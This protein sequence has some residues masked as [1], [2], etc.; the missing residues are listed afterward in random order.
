MTTSEVDQAQET[1]A[2]DTP[3]PPA[4]GRNTYEQ[5]GTG[6]A[7]GN[8]AADPQ[9]RYTESGKLLVKL[10]LACSE[11]K[12][13]P[14]RGIWSEGPVRYLD[15]VCWGR[16]AEN[17]GEH[18]VK[19]DRVVVVGNWQRQRWVDGEGV[20]QQRHTLVATDLGP[21]V[22]FRPARYIAGREGGAT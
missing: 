14:D 9:L 17:V 1:P 6:W 16:L 8:M 3:A 5:L 19:G 7:A 2:P 15:V 12:R 13:D 11:R 20:T 4:P 22:L 18:L 21:S 10:R